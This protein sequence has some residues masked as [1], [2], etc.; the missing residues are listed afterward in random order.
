MVAIRQNRRIEN[1]SWLTLPAT[2]GLNRPPTQTQQQLLP[3]HELE[4]ENFERLCYRLAKT[5]GDVEQWAAL[6]GSRGQKQDGIDIYARRPGENVYSCW[7]SKRH[8]RLTPKLLKAAIAEF[9]KGIWAAKSEEFVICTSASI[10]NNELQ[11]EIETQ[12][13]RLLSKNLK[14][15]VLGQT[16][17][18]TELKD[19][20]R[21][22]RGFF[23]REW[24]RD[25]CEDEDSAHSAD[26]LDAGDIATLRAELRKLYAS[27]FSGLD[28]GILPSAASPSGGSGLLSI[29]GRFVEP[30][31]E[32]PDTRPME[33]GRPSRRTEPTAAAASDLAQ[34]SYAQSA[35]LPSRELLRRRISTW[36]AEGDHTV[37]AGDAGYG[38]STALRVFALDLLEDGSRFPAVAQRWADCI[39]IVVPFAFWVRNR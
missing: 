11:T 2:R 6:Y 8:K 28:P 1:P 32:I 7:Q 35:P 4:W 14:L 36:V 15:T 13:N 16:E 21:L 12:T 19:K 27:N 22:V 3:F 20:S 26:T 18:S 25:F 29:L 31:I 34:I 9:E 17:L 39:P 33:E 37:I 10:Q 30:D 24:A 38:K 5:R 23:G